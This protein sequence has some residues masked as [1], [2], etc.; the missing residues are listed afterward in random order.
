MHWCIIGLA[1]TVAATAGVVAEGACLPGTYSSTGNAPCTPCPPQTYQASSGGLQCISFTTCEP[2]SIVLSGHSG[3]STTNRRCVPCG[4]AKYQDRANAYTCKPWSRCSAGTFVTAD[5]STVSDRECGP[6]DDGSF[7]PNPELISREL[8]AEW[9]AVCTPGLYQAAAPT[10]EADRVC[11][12]CKHG[13]YQDAPGQPECNEW[14]PVCAHGS[15]ELAV[16][17]KKNHREPTPFLLGLL[18]CSC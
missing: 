7:Q 4:P 3:S 10:A 1:A 8:C 6:C 9:S 5:P 18:S 12:V 15:V 17:K 11:V 13:F 2:G 16:R 14:T